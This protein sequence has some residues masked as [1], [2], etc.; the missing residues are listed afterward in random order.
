MSG[1][2]KNVSVVFANLPGVL[3]VDGLGRVAAGLQREVGDG[4]AE[5]GKREQRRGKIPKNLHSSDYNLILG[6][7]AEARRRGE[8]RG[9][10]V[11]ISFSPWNAAQE[12]QDP[13]A[14]SQRRSYCFEA[15]L[16]LG[17]EG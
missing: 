16:T 5:Q 15:R 9:E 17:V 1:E 7:H 3:L 11:R 6:R 2:L 10:H 14:R 13:R 12:S 4:L 8:T